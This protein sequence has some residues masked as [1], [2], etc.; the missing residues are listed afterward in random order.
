[1][2]GFGTSLL[3]KLAGKKVYNYRIVLIDATLCTKFVFSVPLYG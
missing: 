1:M 2:V 3:Q